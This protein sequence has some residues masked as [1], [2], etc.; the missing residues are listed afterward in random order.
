MDIISHALWGYAVLRWRGPRSARWGA[1]VAT[2][3]DLFWS[4][5]TLR[6]YV[7]NNGSK[8]ILSAFGRGEM[9]LKDGPPLPPH[10]IDAY[11]NFYVYSHSFVILALLGLVWYLLRLRPPWLLLPWA[12]HI[13]MDIPTHE[14]YQTPFLF[15]LSGWTIEGWGWV[16]PPVYLTNWAA[17]VATYWGLGWFYWRKG[18]PPRKKPW[19]EEVSGVA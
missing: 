10:L 15:P 8:K 7:V 4:A 9:Y 18:R 11:Y 17:L 13:A 19:P 6:V 16:R 2:V 3:P 14:R 1:L 5:G 12:L